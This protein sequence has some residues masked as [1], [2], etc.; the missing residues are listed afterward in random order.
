MKKVIAILVCI[1]MIAAV[2]PTAF[3]ALGST[4]LVTAGSADYLATGAWYG[5]PTLF[6]YDDGPT[7]YT[8][9]GP[10]DAVYTPQIKIPGDYEVFI[11][12]VAHETNANACKVE[13]NATDGV[14]TMDF[15]LKGEAEF[16][17]VGTYHFD[18]GKSGYVKMIKDEKDTGF[19]RT[20]TVKFELVN[21]TGE[22]VLPEYD[23]PQDDPAYPENG[24]RT[25][26]E[27]DVFVPAGK[28][29][30]TEVFVSPGA[31]GD[32]SSAESPLGSLEAAQQRVREIIAN[33]YPEA[34]ITVQ[35]MEGIYS[36]Q[37]TLVF[38]D[39]DSGTEESPV[40]WQAY[41]GADI[42][43]T[44]GTS[45]NPADFTDVTDESILARLPEEARGHVKVIDLNKAGIT[46][47]Q[48]TDYVNRSPYQLIVGDEAQTTAKWPNVGY[49]RTGTVKDAASR[50]DSGPRK[51]GF[52]YDLNDARS[53]RWETATDAW[54]SGFWLM[55]YTMDYTKVTDVDSEMMTISGKHPTVWGSGG[56][57]RYYI[58]NLL[59]EIDQPSEFF[60][61]TESL[62]L[63]YYPIDG[64]EER[65]MIVA[66]TNSAILNFEN[67]SNVV[68]RDAV[69]EGAGSDGVQFKEESRNNLL[70]GGVIRNVSGVG[71]DVNGYGNGVRDCDI[72]YT[73]SRGVTLAG[74][75][76]TTLEP[77]G[78][79]IENCSIHDVGLTGTSRIG[80][81]M[82]GMGNRISN[83]HLYNIPHQ[84][85][86]GY[87]FLDAVIE[88]NII[89]RTNYDLDDTAAIY[90]N[91]PGFGYGTKIRNNLILD[92]IGIL[93]GEGGGA[94]GFVNGIYL[95][96][97]TCGVEV[98]G[99]IIVNANNGF[100]NNYG[101]DIILNDNVM[102]NTITPA[103]FAIWGDAGG[104]GFVEGGELDVNIK[105]YYNDAFQA[106][107]PQAHTATTMSDSP[108]QPKY[109]TVKNNI[110]VGQKAFSVIPQSVNGGAEENNQSLESVDGLLDQEV[111]TDYAQILAKLGRST[112]QIVGNYK[113]GLRT[114]STAPIVNNR[115]DPFVLQMPANGT[116]YLDPNQITLSW[117]NERGGIIKNEVYIAED[118]E[119]KNIIALETTTHPTLTLDLD[120][121][122]TYYWRVK[123]TPKYE[124]E[125]RWNSGGVFSFTTISA[126]DK[127]GSLLALGEEM[128]ANVE[129]AQETKA[130]L[131]KVM[132]EA[133]VAL[134]SG[135][136]EKMVPAI[137][138]MENQQAVYTAQVIV[139]PDEMDTLIFDDFT[140]DT[141]GERPL[142]LFLRSYQPLD[143][144]AVDLGKNKAV[145]FNDQQDSTMYG[146]RVFENQ[147]AYVEVGADVMAESTN[148][149]FAVSLKQTDR[150]IVATG[151]AT[152]C[153]AKV[154][155][156]N[157]GFIYGDKNKTV[158]LMPY[159]ANTWYKIK[160]CVDFTK[161]TYDVFINGE[162]KGQDIGITDNIVS[163]N[164][165]MFDSSD[166]TNE[167]KLD[168]G[169]FYLDNV[170]VKGLSSTGRN[171]YLKGITINGENLQ[172]FS[173][174]T[175][176]YDTGMTAEELSNA[177]IEV[178]APQ[179]AHVYT[180]AGE[181]GN[182]YLVV[183]SGD[184]QRYHVYTL[185]PQ[186]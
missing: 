161:G 38:S 184:E 165:V 7:Q 52:T 48:P 153:P 183:F 94:G 3:A 179:S 176:L 27:K 42:T 79:Y 120:Y 66:T 74:G 28:A 61:D 168:R 177:K 106:K 87:T 149:S 85:M 59:E 12:R 148:A 88:N 22:A 6:S 171:S 44:T 14:H 90:V 8:G 102:I 151:V 10:A 109:N 162:L 91:F 2:V 111:I 130:E 78:N 105:T 129:R 160:M 169:V 1:T 157:D 15:E 73:G 156:A 150:D 47:I 54:L 140:L 82:T 35:M 60:I 181:N 77:G 5:S 64:W 173:A 9:D 112:D 68:F 41:Q 139:N 178:S 118:P 99:N 97:G 34:G 45:I 142:G 166:G 72:Y 136:T 83:N 98:T 174:D 58:C 56:D 138:A 133:K 152:F 154:A 100:Y 39:A 115:V 29:G 21:A 13:I 186:A 119:F 70:A 32:G 122:K 96:N 57:A 49:G 117:A 17:S 11:W 40:V 113:G 55:E 63:Y 19:V 51:K 67:S 180:R 95:D 141:E 164:Q 92:S 182:L 80:I 75:R 81:S 37:D 104:K 158:Q 84:G 69:L 127:L 76:I 4:I 65:N 175:Y 124:Y 135:D 145:K 143:V 185:K 89:E 110:A 93:E 26:K 24:V 170:I 159:E 137:D 155:F 23:V 16:V 147:N 131:S 116:Q 36:L 146:H 134:A 128:L 46:A 103:N 86:T 53:I 30:A 18:A 167:G 108:N 101:R 33:G 50:S 121:G 114:N 31:N 126:E 62:Q 123:A 132:E 172:G 163:T 125:D 20:G 71:A 25:L 144:T 43:V 107:Y